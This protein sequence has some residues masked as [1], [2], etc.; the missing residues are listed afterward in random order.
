MVFRFLTLSYG[1]NIG[2]YGVS[3]I[4]NLI[5]KL[6]FLYQLK[7]EQFTMRLGAQFLIQNSKFL[8]RTPSAVRRPPCKYRT[9]SKK[10]LQNKN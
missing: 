3:L 6:Q 4:Y 2:G 7:I 8:I 10:M 9:K 5:D 1:T